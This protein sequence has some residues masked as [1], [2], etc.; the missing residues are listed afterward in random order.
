MSFVLVASLA[1]NVL[2]LDICENIPDFAG[3]PQTAAVLWEFEDGNA[4][5]SEADDNPTIIL[6]NYPEDLDANF[7]FRT[8]GSDYEGGLDPNN[9]FVW[10][11]DGTVVCK[12]EESVMQPIPEGEGDNLTV[13]VQVTWQGPN[14]P[15]GD[16]PGI[17]FEIWAGYPNSPPAPGE[18]RQGEDIEGIF[19]EEC[20]IEVPPTAHVNNVEGVWKHTT[21]EHTFENFDDAATHFAVILFGWQQGSAGMLIDEVVIDMVIH[22]GDTPPAGTGRQCLRIPRAGQAR[23]P[24]PAN[25]EGHVL[26]ST[27]LAWAP[28]PCLSGPLD[29]DVYF[30]T[31]SNM[32][33]NPKIASSIGANTVDPNPGGDLDYGT[34]YYW[35]VDTNDA[36]GAGNPVLYTGLDWKFTTLGLADD[37]SPASGA[38]GVNPSVILSW[39]EDDYADSRDIYFGTD[40]VAVTSATTATAGIYRGSTAP[41]DPCDPNRNTYDPP[42]ILDLLAD[43]FWRIDEVNS[44]KGTVKGDVWSFRTTSYF[45]VDDFEPYLNDAAIKAVWKDFWSGILPKNGAE[46]FRE[47]DPAIVR[48]GKSMRYYY[49]NFQKTGGKQVGSVA[50]ASTSAL[51][52]GSDW[53]RQGIKAM[54]LYFRGDPCNGKDTTGLDQDQMYVELASGSDFGLIEYP[55]MNAI[56]ETFWHEWNIELQ[57]FNDAGGVTLSSIDTVYIGFGGYAK[58]GQ[59]SG[60]AGY[61]YGFGDTVYFDDIQLHPPRCV[62]SVS[63]PYGDFTGPYSGGEDPEPTEGDCIIDTWDLFLMSGDWLESDFKVDP[64]PPNDVNLIVEYLFDT[65]FSDTTGNNYHGVPSAAFSPTVSAGVMSVTSGGYVDVEGDFNS[66]NQFSGSKD[67]SIFITYRSLQESAGIEE[68]ALSLITSCDPCLPSTW[69]DPNL[70]EWAA[71]YYSPLMVK[72]WQVPGTKKA[73]DDTIGAMCDYWWKEG[74]VIERAQLGGIGQWHSVAATYD[75]DAGTCP[76]DADP[77]LCTPGQPT[78]LFTAYLDGF[79]GDSANFDPNVPEDSVDD[80][81][82]LCTSYNPIHLEDTGSVPFVGDINDV[83]IYDFPLTHGN[84]LSLGG[85][86][87]PTYFPNTSPANLVLKDPPGGPFDPGNPDIVN[88]R[89]YGVMANNWLKE[90]LWPLP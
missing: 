20:I 2:A 23:D 80:I 25:T 5:S 21:Y 74:S 6:Y 24:D 18:E 10:S 68:G 44:I 47:T 86:D 9:A 75:A 84:V 29:Y 26:V 83:R 53:S 13:H 17:G 54:T 72:T 58:T 88:F 27:D 81:V 73:P 71:M 19:N 79:K 60:G 90:I 65:D 40:E 57:D 7:G 62:P 49:R 87:Q 69:D 38:R 33:N 70:E 63:L 34:V 55:D 36:N 77:N 61:T 52:A 15:G 67:Y 42:E 51:Q 43:A 37:E 31:D 59:T 82:R 41:L 35:R 28:D 32:A 64:V 11:P 8:Y 76:D 30:G 48:A 89:D 39:V 14:C 66:L 1:G 46:V 85:I 56:K 45:V 16:G 12:G 22:D 78:G 3:G 50:Q 4:V